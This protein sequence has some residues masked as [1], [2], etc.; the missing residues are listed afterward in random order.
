MHNIFTIAKNTFKE[1]IRDRVLYGIIG[2]AV[3]FLAS[4]FFI[5]SLSLGEDIKV[6]RDLGLA[7]IYIF[8]ILVTIFLG[9][10]LIYK[11][12]E[13]RTIYIILSKPVTT[14][15]FLAGK[16]L[17]L[18]MGIVLNVSLMT[19][20]YLIIV[21]IKGGGFDAIALFSIFLLLFEVILFIALSVLFS[22]FTSP[23]AGTIYSVIILYTGHSLSLLITAADKSGNGF[24]KVIA[25][26]AYYLFPNL[27]KFNFRNSIIYG[28]LPNSG[29]ILFPVIYSLCFSVILLWLANLA[30]KKQEL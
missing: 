23:L 15:Q 11:E 30:L 6:V 7:G 17:G 3:L 8:T 25:Y 14:L 5:S 28:T 27:E 4:T 9:T 13:K 12:L 18:F 21:A 29:Q 19:I 16:S 26:L 24:V 20:L 1:T 2:F 10:P 22:V